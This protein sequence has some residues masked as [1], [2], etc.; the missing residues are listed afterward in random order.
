MKE[1]GKREGSRVW[2]RCAQSILH[3]NGLMYPFMIIFEHIKQ[4]DFKH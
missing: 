2:E 1:E 3:A 4:E